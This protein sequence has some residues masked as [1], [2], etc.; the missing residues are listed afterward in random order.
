M[1]APPTHARRGEHGTTRCAQRVNIPTTG[2]TH[3]DRYQLGSTP[4]LK[5][6]IAHL[7]RL[8]AKPTSS[9]CA[10]R[11]RVCRSRRSPP[12]LAEGGP[13]CYPSR[14]GG[15]P[16]CDRRAATPRSA[17]DAELPANR[18][19]LSRPLA[20]AAGRCIAEREQPGC[21]RDRRVCSIST[22]KSR[23]EQQVIGPSDVPGA[24]TG[25]VEPSAGARRADPEDFARPHPRASARDSTLRCPSTSTTSRSTREAARASL[26]A[27]AACGHS[28]AA[29]QF[30][31][32]F[33]DDATAF[34]RAREAVNHPAR[35]TAT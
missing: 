13:G 16:H 23:E 8:P 17:R 10:C 3:S 34:S 22:N 5:D 28:A 14:T 9:K 2:E 27:V 1:P 4:R 15:L 26:R 6:A 19:R 30:R 32:R 35:A 11:N 29:G 24:S 21:R 33:L 18:G 31:S 20:T 7:D 25:V 12:V